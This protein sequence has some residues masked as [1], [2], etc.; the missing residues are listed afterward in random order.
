[1]Q[2]HLEKAL[3]GIAG[4]DVTTVCAGRTDAG[5]HALAQVV[6]FDTASRRPCSAWV[7]GTN[8]GLPPAVAVQWAREVSDAFHARYAAQRRSYRYVLLNRPVR[9]AVA[10]GRAGWFHLPLD[11][12]RMRSAAERL[13]GEHDF[14]A[15]RSSECQARNP[16]RTLHRIDIA[17]AGDYVIFDFCAN[18]FLHHMVR[19]LVGTLV[20]IGK[21]GQ[22]PEWAAQV[23]AGRDRGRAA[24]TFAADGLY[25]A[26]VEYDAAWQL[27]TA[28]ATVMGQPLP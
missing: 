25:L 13:V 28:T 23:L 21:G 11:I 3:R 20:Y 27:P 12:E 18:A 15:F 6:H 7:R 9:P 4:H 19:N 8:A 24:P 17:R 10:C 26:A 22:E 16:V 5:V 1:M 2:D 14:S